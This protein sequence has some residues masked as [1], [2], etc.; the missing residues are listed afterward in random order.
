METKNNYSKQVTWK[1]ERAPEKE[2]KKVA[3]EFWLDWPSYPVLFVE[4]SNFVGLKSLLSEMLQV[5]RLHAIE[6]F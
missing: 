4:D 2:A 5:E 6:H 3:C 1:I